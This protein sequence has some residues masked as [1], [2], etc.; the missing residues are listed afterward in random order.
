MNEIDIFTNSTDRLRSLQTPSEE[1][2]ISVIPTPFQIGERTVLLGKRSQG[3]LIALFP[4]EGEKANLPDEPIKLSNSFQLATKQLLDPKTGIESRY[5]EFSNV[6]SIDIALFGA[7]IDELLHCIDNGNGNVTEE[8][9]DLLKKWKNLLALDEA[10]L[11]SL[12]VISG[13]FGELLLLDHLLNRLELD[14]LDIWVGPNGNRHDF[15]FSSSSIEVKTTT[16]RNGDE[17]RV[18]GSSQLIPYPGK[19]VTILRIKLE[20]EPNGISLPDLI[21]RIAETKNIDSS[22]FNEKLSKI[23]YR[24]AMADSYRSIC[25]QLVELQIIPVDENFPRISP[26]ALQKIDSSGRSHEVEY[27]VNVSGLQ[28]QKSPD[29]ESIKFEGLVI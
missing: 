24:S 25:F 18:N 9:H 26:D 29:L 8:I 11:L 15:E 16:V 21:A 28:T 19:S 23:G 1:Q 27:S 17:I 12:N 7:L 3:H 6:G 2:G 14:A 20:I 5:L 22:K 13:L 10:K 4:A